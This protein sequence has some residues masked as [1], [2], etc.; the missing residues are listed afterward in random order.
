MR[1]MNVKA[2]L[3]VLGL[4]LSQAASAQRALVLQDALPMGYDSLQQELTV[5]GITYDV[6][7]RTGLTNL[8]NVDLLEYHMVFVSECQSD[9]FYEDFNTD[10]ARYESFVFRGG[11]LSIHPSF[12][13]QPGNT[14]VEFPGGM[15]STVGVG[16]IDMG[17]V[18]VPGHLLLTSLPTFFYGN[19]VAWDGLNSGDLIAG[20][21]VLVYDGLFGLPIA[22]E[23]FHGAGAAVVS[24]MLV[25]YAY[26]SGEDAGQYH[27][28]QVL[29]GATFG[30]PD[31][32]GDG[33]CDPDDPCPLDAPDD[34]DIDGVCDSDDVCPGQNDNLDSDGDGVPNGCDLCPGGHDI[35]DS[36]GDG[37]VDGCDLCP[38]DNP[39][40]SDDDGVCDSEDRCP[41]EDDTLDQ[42]QDEVPD[43]CD[44]CP[45]GDDTLDTDGDGVPD[46]CD[47]CPLFPFE[48]D[49]D[50][51]GHWT[52]EDCQDNDPNIFLGAPET[53][54]DGVDQDCDGGDACYTD[55]DLDGFGGQTTVA[56]VDLDCDDA[57]EAANS[58]DCDDLDPLV[59]PDAVEIDFD[60]EDQN[61]DGD[62]GLAGDVDSDGDGL[63][64]STEHELGSD[65]NVEDTD[66]DGVPDG[67]E[68][69]EDG[70]PLDT[71]GDGVLNVLDP[72]DDGDGIDTQ[73]EGTDDLDGDG[74]PNY[75]DLDSDGDGAAD[76][77]EG[78]ENFLDNGGGDGDAASPPAG[79][80][81]YGCGCS[82]APVSP[83]GLGLS[84]MLLPLL[85]LR[86]RR[87]P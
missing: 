85:L 44:I 60:D 71:D 48:E 80:G 29:Y 66:G 40:D 79:P 78:P 38:F 61:C 67:S 17:I 86:R 33:V 14:A 6:V 62:P 7:G 57:G 84:L 75:L 8:T 16:W 59:N 2:P 12:C 82:A 72:D 18:Q 39:D 70:G 81:S 21:I 47:L 55:L 37:T 65:P 76:A 73:I 31:F 52:C 58:E 22:I 87:N 25:S 74:T 63:L 28:N 27:E 26:G 45:G 4:F 35:L 77:A 24:T 54:A 9:L 42:D 83:Q 46:D 53:V 69:G 13:G 50:G 64:D 56:S 20:D 1:L 30:C 32:D 51:D 3:L 41:G 49:R 15:I 43:A 36:D 68:V 11:F 5:R 19:P 10:F 23:R 34:S